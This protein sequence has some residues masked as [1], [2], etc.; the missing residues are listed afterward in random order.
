MTPRTLALVQCVLG[1]LA[2]AEAVRP[3]LWLGALV[4]LAG[5]WLASTGADRQSSP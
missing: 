1:Y 3:Q 2:F 5:V 4:I